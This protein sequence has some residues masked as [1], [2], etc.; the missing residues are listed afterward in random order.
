MKKRF[1]AG[2]LAFLMLLSLLPAAA[3]KSVDTPV[4]SISA[5]SGNL[6]TQTDLLFDFS[7][8]EADQTRYNTAAYGKYNF[9]TE[10]NGYWATGYNGSKT[11]YTISNANGTLRLGVTDG[12]DANG[13]YGPWLKVTNKY[14][15]APSYSE[16]SHA[17]YPLNFNPKN[18][19]YVTIKFKMSGCSIPDG[20]VPRLVFEYY[21]TKDGAYSYANDMRASFVFQ[22][23]Y[24]QTVTIPV[25][26]KL[27]SADSLKGFGFR[28]Q[29]VKATDGII[30]VDYIY[31]GASGSTV[32]SSYSDKT[33][34]SQSVNPILSGVNESQIYLKNKSDSTQIA[35][36]LATVSPS[37]KATFKVS[38]PGYYTVG[39]T[40]A[41]RKTAADTLSINREK[42]TVQAATYESVTGDKVY[43]AVNADFFNMDTGHPRGQLAMEGNILQTYG[44]R[45]T[46]YFAVL[47]DGT[48]A[49]RAFGTPMGDVQEAAAG[50]HWLVRD[51]EI[52]SN[53]DEL[54]PRTAIGLKA[55]GTV[56]VFAVDGRQEP[57]SV[58]MNLVELAEFMKAAG[59]VNAINLDG[60]GSTTF[61]TRYNN[62]ASALTIRNKPCDSDGERAVTS[63]LLLVAQSCKHTYNKNYTI[64]ADGTHSVTCA[65]CSE[66]ITVT[67]SYQNGVC[68]CGDKQHMGSGLFF[69][70]GNSDFDRYRYADP[71]YNY[72]NFDQTDNGVWNKGYWYT[73]YTST[74]KDYAI[75][76]SAGT[77]TVNV[78]EGY[79]GSAENNNLV[80]GPWLKLTN[81]DG[82]A[83]TKTN[84]T[85][86]PLNYDPQNVSQVKIRFKLTGCT[87]PSDTTPKVIFEYYYKKDGTYTGATDMGATYTFE[88]NQYVTVTIPA[89]ATLK[90]ADT[91][92]GFGFRFQ[93]IKS[94][95]GGKLTVDYIYIGETA[96]DTLL[97]QFDNSEAAKARYQD[98]AYNFINFDAASKGSWH[99]YY[100]GA[101]T[102][103][104]INHGTGTMDVT[105]TENYSSN[106]EGTNIIYGPWLKTTNTYGKWTGK[107]T[108]DYYPLSYVPKDAEYFQIRFKT[109][110]CVVAD[111]KTPNLVLEYYYTK[112]GVYKTGYLNATY[113]LKNGE[114]QILTIPTNATFK[115]ADEIQCFGL[116]FQHIKSS[117]DGAV[118]ID[119]IAIG[120]NDK[121]PNPR[122]TVTFKGADGSTLASQTLYKGENATYTGATPSKASDATNHY[123]FSGWDKALS[124]ISANTTFTAQFTAE[125]HTLSYE[126]NG[127]THTGLCACGYSATD[128]HNWNGGE[129]TT[130]PTCSTEGVT[131]YTCTDCGASKTEAVAML[132]HTE[133]IDEA[134]APTCIETGLTEGN[135]CAT[136]GEVLVAQTTVD[137][138]GHTEVIDAG[139]EAECDA[140]G[141][142]EGK[143]CSVCGEVLVA[144]EVIRMLGHT[145]VIDEAVAP[146]CT[147]TGLT[148]GSHCATCGE[149]IVAQ[150]T[151]DALG[152]TEVIDEAVAPTCTETGLTEGS[153]CAICGE[154]IVAQTTVDALG[155]T[156]VIDEA[157]SPT[158]TE[159]GLTEGKHCSVCG[160]VLVAQEV[161]PTIG[162][163]EVIDEA[164][165]PTCTETG[166]TQGSHCSVCGEV[167]VARGILDAL[168]HS[169]KYADN[170]DKT[171][172]VTCENCDFTEIADCVFENGECICG[173]TEIAEPIYDDAVKFSHSLTLENDISINFIGLGS[174]LS[175]YDSFYLECK[176]PVYNGNEL[177]GY[178]IVNIEPVYNGKNY[179]FTLLGVTAKM[180]NDDIEAVFRMTKDGQEYYSKTDVYSVA[181]YAYGKLNST[182]ASDTD[183]LKAICA[184]LLR[185]GALAQ[186]QFNYRT[187]ALVDAAMTEAHK[188]YLTDLATVEMK[189]YRKQL[190]D[191]ETVIV[192]WKS[193]TLELGN[194]VIMC[195]IVNLANYTG[196]PA[197]LTMRLTYVDSNGL[198]V[199]EERA[200]ELY[201]PD[202]QTYAVS[203]DGLRATE[204]RSIVSAAIYNGD[205]RVS[206][207]VEYSIESY[208]AR[209]SDTAMRE[210]CLA[211]LAYGDAA[212]AFF[213]K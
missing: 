200:L 96:S 155:H 98:P 44:T 77:L 62:G 193:T 123:S 91:L 16:S 32:V 141:L 158:C 40:A 69:G 87:V 25:S 173:A 122:Y 189:D 72:L 112:D 180:M 104:A 24:Y 29:N 134:I 208:G 65:S 99:S 12:A 22:N 174:A 58:G 30:Y 80:Y 102:N 57:Y 37:A 157:V 13:T 194:K 20:T 196:N 85:Y 130:Q 43:L 183:E 33:F 136:C 108:Y 46:P 209:S 207:T 172:T 145:E 169:Y 162:H 125:A 26:S 34:L 150:T 27:T 182:K 140:T 206:K 71:A 178:E 28:F 187:D 6:N 148:E 147:K 64:H 129:I 101:N 93:N 82:V 163:T 41:S 11:N 213:S 89:S 100:N 60:G 83:S 190:N 120:P 210:L 55:D 116:R 63:C 146:T 149:V 54:H 119:Y 164:V 2:I 51:G 15:T 205:T 105:V 198:T 47:K 137:A 67:H 133:V 59:C 121:L 53:T 109:T 177:T 118:N 17:Y 78:N 19:K 201:N 7:N 39:S 95:S 139:Y 9:D 151:V 175:V 115:S 36:Y 204:M 73:G 184:N 138:L 52:V 203:Y 159:T 3:A 45:A 88:E 8:K 31:I 5:F 103:F 168:G 70:F 38:Y 195:L 171:H 166:L 74:T 131:T 42:T 142:T 81:A 144:Q 21:Y 23:G 152:H 110:N 143:H 124:D 127:E 90:A 212:N 113:T 48:Y 111:G 75:N 84:A 117:A 49:I 106:S 170:S 199:T 153:H 107:D 191:L 211:M 1:T 135:H 56:V 179:E 18:V 114:F 66:K 185:Y 154:V 92:C 181:E 50:Y 192:P 165:A 167:L 94:T 197:E 10:T 132:G 79:S 35:G 76:H 186:T 61:A 161:I 4:E 68:A 97:F 160:E 128:G 86:S 126:V 176:V 188:A 202:A 156:E 14:G